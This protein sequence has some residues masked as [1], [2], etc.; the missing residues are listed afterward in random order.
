GSVVK[1]SSRE[2]KAWD[3][4]FLETLSY[5]GLLAVH[6]QIYPF[7]WDEKFLDITAKRT[8]RIRRNTEFLIGELNKFLPTLKNPMRLKT[9][10]HGLFFGVFYKGQPDY[11][12]EKF[13]KLAM[14]NQVP[15]K[16]CDSFGFD[17]LSL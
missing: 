14:L 1:L 8:E 12:P 9:F 17:F 10:E 15:A 7:L 13:L 3:K 2:D 6:E 11:H 5:A 4:F 16:H